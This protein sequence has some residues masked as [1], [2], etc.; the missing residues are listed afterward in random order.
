M[1]PP[2]YGVDETL[3]AAVKTLAA[4]SNG[5]SQELDHVI[6]QLGAHHVA[7]FLATTA[8]AHAAEALRRYLSTYWPAYDELIERL[9]RAARRTSENEDL[10]SDFGES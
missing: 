9:I 6:Q 2:H 10:L 1:E 3:R 4:I 5:T 8:D 7:H